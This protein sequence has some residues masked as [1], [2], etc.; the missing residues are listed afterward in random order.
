MWTREKS[1]RSARVVSV[2]CGYKLR[3][4]R[5]CQEAMLDPAWTAT[6]LDRASGDTTGPRGRLFLHIGQGRRA[7]SYLQSVSYRHT[8]VGKDPL[9]MEP[10]SLACNRC[11]PPGAK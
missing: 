6:G 9:D 11:T 10:I 2:T 1:V 7:V 8:S 3:F 4:F 5:L